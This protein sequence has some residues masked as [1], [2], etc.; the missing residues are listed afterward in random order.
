M[1][2]KKVLFKRREDEKN[3]EDIDIIQ[4]TRIKVEEK[5]DKRFKSPNKLK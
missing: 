5:R 3:K 4:E 2:K 1:L